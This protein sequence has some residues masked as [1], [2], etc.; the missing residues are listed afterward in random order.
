MNAYET[1][2]LESKKAGLYGMLAEYYKYSNPE[3]HEFYYRKHFKTLRKLAEWIERYGDPFDSAANQT[4]G[5]ESYPGV[6]SA[7]GPGPG[8]PSLGPPPYPGF[9][10][11]GAGYIPGYGQYGAPVYGKGPPFGL[12]PQYAPGMTRAE[13]APARVR[14]L[15]ASPDTS[16]VDIY[17]NGSAVATSVSFKD[18]TPYLNVQPGTYQLEIRPADNGTARLFQALTV[19]E[20]NAYTVAAGGN[21]GQLKL[22]VYEDNL[23]PVSG[24]S[25]LRFIHLAPNTPGIDISSK[26]GPLLFKTEG[27]G[28]ATAYTNLKPGKV[29]LQIVTS[30]ETRTMLEINGVS[31]QEDSVYTIL[32][33]GL[34]DGNP[35]IEALLLKDI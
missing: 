22:F 35:P 13:Q 32:A 17:V 24:K 30:G 11:Y 4:R 20:G 7:A 18:V 14:L 8:S 1:I 3:L 23:A 5:Q 15:H 29:D 6:Y 10:K 33:V 34:G 16:A 31:L 21:A 2:M 26:N 9:G 28:A 19:Q 25:S 12:P 27:F